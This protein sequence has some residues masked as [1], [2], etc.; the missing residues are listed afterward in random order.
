MA[1][2]RGIFVPPC[3]STGCKRPSTLEVRT[4]RNTHFGCFCEEHG[5]SAVVALHCDE[6][7]K[8]TPKPRPAKGRMV[9]KQR[10]AR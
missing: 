5:R 7:A 6:L 4:R 8:P 10:G 3:G 9:G 1:S 2:I